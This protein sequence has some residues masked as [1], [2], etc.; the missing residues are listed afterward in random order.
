MMNMLERCGSVIKQFCTDG[1]C[2]EC[3]TFGKGHI[4]STY[5][6]CCRNA[7]GKTIKYV[8]QAINTYVF[9]E[10]DKLMD[11]I[12]RVTDFL[13]KKE[14]ENRGILNMIR[15]K[16]GNGFYR[17]DEGKCWRMYVYVDDALSLETVG[18]P[19]D[20]YEA[21]YAFGKFQHDLS[22]F[23]ADTLFEIIPDFHNTEKRYQD[24]LAA[25]A[26]DKSGRAKNVAQEIKFIKDRA[27][28][29]SLLNNKFAEGVIP[30][31]V[32]HNDTKLNNVLLDKFT[33]KALCVLDLDTIMPG[34]SVT[35]FGDAIRFG[36]N[37]AVEDE[38][39]ISKVWLNLDLF[40]AYTEGYL[41]GCAGK[42]CN[43]EI[44]LLPEGAKMMTIECG[45][46]FL[47]DYIEGDLYFKTAYPEHNLVRA[48]TQLKLVYDM[49]KHFD[50]MKQIV[51]TYCK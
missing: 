8:M 20:F 18:L 36:A 45:M 49:E 10:P 12:I 14:P 31:R 33:R 1:E 44:M 5:L 9:K 25:V 26:K 11:N 7:D 27:E 42:L 43:E 15:T 4:N 32:T 17:D 46:R 28:F 41:S 24:F 39:D 22:D 2:Y 30:L 6:V 38:K 23:P 21:A 3:K 13:R 29:Y 37:N 51:S 16:D 40:K 48:R 47:A 19:D 50:D 34:F 35:D